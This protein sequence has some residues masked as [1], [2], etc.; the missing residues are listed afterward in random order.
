MPHKTLTVN[1]YTITNVKFIKHNRL[2]NPKTVT[3]K[4][5]S[6]YDSHTALKLDLPKLYLL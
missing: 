5:V 2:C 3:K 6:C 1:T 4:F